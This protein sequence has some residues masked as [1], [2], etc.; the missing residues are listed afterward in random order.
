MSSTLAQS[1][2]TTVLSKKL[3]E[4][5]QLSMPPE[6][7][8]KLMEALGDSEIGPREL[9]NIIEQFPSIGARLVSLVNSAWSAP[10]EPI[11]SIERACAHLGLRLVH[12]VSISLAVMAPFDPGRCRSFE[13]EIYWCNTFLVADSAAQLAVCANTDNMLLP[14]TARTAG[15]FH[16]LGLLWL[17]DNFPEETERA[18]LAARDD[19]I[20]LNESL[21]VFCRADACQ[22]GGR[23][24]RAWGLPQ[25]LIAAI[26][27]RCN[28]DYDGVGW[29][30]ASLLQSATG[31]VNAVTSGTDDSVV[32]S[33]LERLT[34]DARDRDKVVANIVA[35]F[36]DTLELAKSL[37]L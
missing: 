12:S 6:A 15:L 27:H 29:Q 19:G 36:D 33:S 32:D 17:A 5:T 2:S 24:G 9:A 14:E 7:L 8:P 18:L 16:N 13:S 11:L 1:G 20:D 30:V 21:R 25:G 35:R 4:D 37:K 31:I 10:V 34:I 28:P 3:A 23:L 26:E 22:I